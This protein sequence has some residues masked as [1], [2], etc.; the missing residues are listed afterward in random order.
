MT[1]EQTANSLYKGN[2]DIAVACR[3]AFMLGAKK[4]TDE[5]KS[6][7]ADMLRSEILGDTESVEDYLEEFTERMED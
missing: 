7:F 6:V 5:A 2:D 3:K 4:A 1:Q